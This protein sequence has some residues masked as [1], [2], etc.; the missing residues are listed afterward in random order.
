[1]GFNI[2]ASKDNNKTLEM[3]V[4]IIIP[5]YNVEPYVARCL[6]SVMAQTYQGSI[7]CLIVDDCGTDRSMDVVE[8]MV[9][10]YHGSISFKILHHT[11][12]R[13]LSAARNTGM[14]AATGE[15]IYFLDSD[16]EISEDC[17]ERL[18]AP[19]A[20]ERYDIIV[21]NIIKKRGVEIIKKGWGLKLRNNTV[22]RGIELENAYREKWNMMAQNKLYRLDFICL[23]DL[24]FKEG[25][26]HEDELWSLQVACLAQSLRAVNSPTY[27]YYVREGSI[28]TSANAE[29]RKCHMLKIIAI[30]ICR[31]LKERNIFSAKAYLIMQSFFFC[32]LK[33]SL[34]NRKQYIQHYCDLR[35]ATHLSLFY[36]LKASGLH[37]RSQLLNLYLLLPPKMAGMLCYHI[38]RW[39]A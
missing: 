28:T 25:I 23:Q 32:S 9:A 1:M 35:K 5:I 24:K 26:V 19:L 33:S 7:E 4:S 2:S 20:E 16:D 29:E 10:N 18:S 13:G 11:Y 21:G 12:N 27:I 31:F 30:E 14:A 3:K 38:N 22:L 39:G 15:Y 36:C 34:E 17:I 8:R 37:P 6:H